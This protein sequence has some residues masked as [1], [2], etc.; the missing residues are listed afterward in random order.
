[1]QTPVASAGTTAINVIG[2]VSTGG[3]SITGVNTINATG[4]INIGSGSAYNQL[5]SNCDVSI[6]GSVSVV[7]ISA[8]RNVCVTGGASVSGTALANGSV[9]AQSGYGSNGTLSALANATGVSA[10]LTSGTGGNGNS[11]AATCPAPALSGVDLWAG[12][13]GA[14]SVKT[15]GSVQLS[16]GRI[17]TLNAQ[18]NL[19]VDSGSVTTG[20]IGGTVTKP[21]WNNAVNV[22]ATNG[23][24]VGIAPAPIVTIPSSTFNAYDLQSLANYAF[25]VNA[26]GYPT[27]A[28]LNINGVL[29]GTYFLGNYDGG[30]VDYLCAALTPGSSPGS[31]VCQTPA[32]ASGTKI[33]KG[34]SDYNSCFSY[35]NGTW[36]IVGTS[37]APGIAW[38]KGNLTVGTGTYYNT[39]IAT[40]NIIT[41]G[42]HV[43]YAP[44]FAGYS[45]TVSGK[46]YAPTG[47]CVNSLF[48]FLYPTQLCTIGT[49]TYNASAGSGV[50][51][52]AFMAGSWP[53]TTHT[54]A[55]YVGGNITIGA[56]SV[57]HGSIKAGNEFASGG[58]TTITGS[59]NALALG[60][61]VQN[62][63]GGS[64]TFDLTQFPPTFDMTGGGSS[65]G[66]SGTTPAGV[67]IQWARYL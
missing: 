31:P 34:Y 42:Q 53:G 49:Q 63:M 52:F 39:F 24:T 29:N 27:V 56:S 35:S 16:S 32:L 51:N 3:N 67:S 43:T 57:I 6:T 22:T 47:I 37:M 9:L 21:A 19:K 30:H 23:Y 46:Q 54:Q 61:V 4:S 59:V 17:G 60:L 12:G 7:A 64:T 58:S 36:N 45:G 41:S 18:G 62:S 8:R 11:S 44:N 10:C 66:S 1:V 14:Q 38:F 26:G 65:G 40:G 48:P 50:G 15:A 28:V 25:A 33:C 13:A 20:T 5:N 55:S 2:D